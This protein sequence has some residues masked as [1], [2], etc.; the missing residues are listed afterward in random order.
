MRPGGSG[1]RARNNRNHVR[2]GGGGGGGGGNRN[3][4]F[5]SNGPE[6]KVRGSA[7]Q[8]AEKYAA[9]ARDA[10]VA[11]DR[12]AA[13]NYLQHAEHYTRIV[14]ANNERAAEIA[15][16]TRERA[17]RERQDEPEPVPEPVAVEVENG[18]A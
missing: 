15:E 3:Q 13:E 16:A 14:N 10:S 1:K 8:V 18:R 11:G 2:R 9:L 17:D 12:V 6:V 5:D 7:S 4:S